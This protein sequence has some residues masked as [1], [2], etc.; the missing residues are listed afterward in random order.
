MNASL[1]RDPRRLRAARIRI[2]WSWP[3]CRGIAFALAEPLD[4]DI[5]GARDARDHRVLDAGATSALYHVADLSLFQSGHAR[6]RV[7]RNVE[8]VKREA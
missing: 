7:L 2:G 6:E 5:E 8:F 1:T 3:G 4:R